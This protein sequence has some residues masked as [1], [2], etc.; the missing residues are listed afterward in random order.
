MTIIKTVITVLNLIVALL[1]AFF[2]RTEKRS[3]QSFFAFFVF[4][5]CAN[6]I[7]IWN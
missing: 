5:F 3:E 2:A 4:L 7:L 1:M 6:S